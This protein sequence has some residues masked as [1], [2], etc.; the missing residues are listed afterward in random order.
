MVGHLI[1]AAFRGFFRITLVSLFFIA[2][3]FGVSLLVAYQV[4]QVWPPS[5]PAYVIAGAIGLLLGY[6][7]GL[8]TLLREILRGV[9]TAE[10]EIEAGVQEIEE[11]ATRL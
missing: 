10:H 3:G 5:T 4:T 8:T 7:A 6:A 1:K 11:R 2:L 9:K